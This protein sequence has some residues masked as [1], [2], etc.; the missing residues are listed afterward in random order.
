MSKFNEIQN[1]LRML[2]NCR[3]IN[4]HDYKDYNNQYYIC[5]SDAGETLLKKDLFI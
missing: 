5:F 2:F 4:L 1:Y 3:F